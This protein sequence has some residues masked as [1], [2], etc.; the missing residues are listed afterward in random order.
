MRI[1]EHPATTAYKKLAQQN[2]TPIKQ[3]D[4]TLDEFIKRADALQ[5]NIE[6]L[7]KDIKTLHQSNLS[8]LEESLKLISK[9]I[10]ILKNKS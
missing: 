3:V 8:L 6:M 9:K 10:N 5:T 4:N 1:I 7:K 2:K